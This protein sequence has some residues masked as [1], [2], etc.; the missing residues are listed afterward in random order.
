MHGHDL[1][2]ANLGSRG[3]PILVPAELCD[4]FDGQHFTGLLSEMDTA[5]MIKYACLPPSHNATLI[6]RDGMDHFG[7]RPPAEKPVS[8]FGVEVDMNMAV[9][10]GRVLPPPQ[11]TYRGSTARANDGSW[12][13][14]SVKFHQ[15]ASLGNWVVLAVTDNPQRAEFTGADDPQLR[16]IVDGFMA[17]CRAVGMGVPK[18]PV[19]LV[20]P[21]LPRATQA[22]PFRQNAIDA[23]DGLL[24]KELDPK[25]KP[26]FIL[27]IL[28]GREPFIFP[29][30]KHLCDVKLGLH[31]VVVLAQKIKKQQGQDQ[32]FSNVALKVNVKLGGVN[33][34]L[35]QGAMRWLREKKTM[36]VGMDVTH[37]GPASRRGAPSIA[38]VVASVDDNF[39]Q[40]PASMELQKNPDRDA[41]EVSRR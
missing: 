41:A 25:S 1:P 23:I 27:T 14:L 4:I 32:Y 33:H 7:L 3:K 18:A 10:P 12:N 39:A 22:D 5:A 21:P 16:A 35:D 28:P 8:G 19:V 40:Y 13:V 26:S 9:V 17:K 24:R 34:I 30:L 2:L 11:I 20:T 38:A 29:G 36:I 37:P 31:T 6:T 15:P